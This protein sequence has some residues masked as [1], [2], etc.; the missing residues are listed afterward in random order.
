MRCSAHEAKPGNIPDKGQDQ[1][2]ELGHLMRKRGKYD[3]TE[4]LVMGSTGPLSL[5]LRVRQVMAAP[6][7]LAAGPN[8]LTAIARTWSSTREELETILDFHATEWVLYSVMVRQDIG[9]FVESTWWRKIGEK[10]YGVT[11]GYGDRVERIWWQH[12]CPAPPDFSEWIAAENMN[13]RLVDAVERVNAELL[14]R[15]APFP[16]AARPLP[17]RDGLDK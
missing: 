12:H 3:L 1:P 8:Q 15:N 4:F 7:R 9:K 5:F 13:Q 14:A 6:R 17:P 10:F 16:Q 11:I 2:E